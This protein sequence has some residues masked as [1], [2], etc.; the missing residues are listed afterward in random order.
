MST[1]KIWGNN[2]EG[3]REL[4]DGEGMNQLKTS[5]NYCNIAAATKSCHLT[6]STAREQI[7]PLYDTESKRPAWG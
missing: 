4:D 7:F 3:D 5:R 1:A 2:L 6:I